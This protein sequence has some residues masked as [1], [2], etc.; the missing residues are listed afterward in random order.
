MRKLRLF[1][2]DA[3]AWRKSFAVFS[4]AVAAACAASDASAADIKTL[5]A[6]KGASTWFVEDHTVPMIAIDVSLPAGSAYDPGVKAGLAAFAGSLLDEGAAGLDSTAFHDALASRAI[7]LSVQ[8]ERDYLVISMV[9]ETENAKEAFRLLGLA[10]QHPRFD[11]DAVARVR[12]QMLEGLQQEDEEPANIAAKGFAAT[13]FAGHPYAHPVNGVPAGINAITAQDLKSFARTHWVR[14]GMRIAVSGDATPATIVSLL[15]D[16]FSGLPANSPPPPPPVAHMGK[17]GVQ[18][19]PLPLP[20]PTVVFGI[21]AIPRSDPDF[22]PGYVANYIVGG[23]GFS[24]RLTNEVR[25]KRGLTYGIETGLV[26]YRR[27]GFISGEVATRRDSVLQTISVTRAVLAKFAAEG[28]TE[29]ELAD[30]K[31]YLTGSFPLAFASNAGIAGQLG[32][33]QRQELGPDYV[34]KRNALIG[35]VSLE[36]V[37]RVAKRLFDP[38]SM[39]VVVAGSPAPGRTPAAA[40]R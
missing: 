28:P 2:R 39:T 40:H 32:V 33:F 3:G 35:A 12:A 14:G 16:A 27:A 8:A 20:Q 1:N 37:R 24:S 30:A 23:G 13:F 22:I 25:V 29:Q 38:R 6:V 19:I 31:T 15:S 7:I 10:L 21:P 9:T 36:D 26:A 4:L 18:I 17:P 34:A 5:S 11:G